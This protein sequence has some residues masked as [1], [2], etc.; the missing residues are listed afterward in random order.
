METIID[1]RKGQAPLHILLIGNNPIELG[2]VLEKLKQIRER[3]IVTEIAFDL[4]SIMER[5]ARFNPNFIFIDDNIGRK[6]LSE[7]VKALSG[8]R[9][10][11]NIP[12]AVLK[13][14]NYHESLGSAGIPDYLLKQ[15]LSPENLFNAVRNSLKLRQTHL[16]LYQAYQKRKRKLIA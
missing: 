4:K 6:G 14:S 13:N 1:K 12:I 8:S 11:K 7:T 10:T 15:N 16:Y 3:I 2:G 9:R 5:L